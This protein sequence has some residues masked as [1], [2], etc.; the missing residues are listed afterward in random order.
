M[1]ASRQPSMAP[2]YA[3]HRELTANDSLPETTQANGINMAGYKRA[4]IRVVTDGSCNPTIQVQFWS[5]ESATP[6]F[7]DDNI[8]LIFPGAGAGVDYEV[9]VD[10]NGRDMFVAVP[11]GIGAL[12]T[13]MVMVA[14]VPN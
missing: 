2:T 10:C 8:G 12:E 3:I 11:S 1:V 9:T 14:G 6:K 4:N 5:A 13:A 7:V